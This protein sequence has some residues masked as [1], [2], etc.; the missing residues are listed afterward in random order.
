MKKPFSLEPVAVEYQGKRAESSQEQIVLQLKAIHSQMIKFFKIDFPF[1]GDVKVVE[2]VE[3]QNQLVKRMEHDLKDSN[4]IRNNDKWSQVSIAIS[5][6]YSAGLS[7]HFAFYDPQNDILHFN[8]KMV[9]DYPERVISVCAHEL[10]E[11]LLSFIDPSSQKRSVQHAAKLYFETTNNPD[12]NQLQQV[13]D[14]YFETIFKTIFKEGCCEAIA[15]QILRNMNFNAEAARSDKELQS[16]YLKCVG[17]LSI[18]ECKRK[19]MMAAEP[20]QTEQKPADVQAIFGE[21]LKH[22]QIIKSV[23]YYLGYPLAREVLEKYGLYGVCSLIQKAMQPK[24]EHFVNP[25]SY[26]AILETTFSD[27]MEKRK[28]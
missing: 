17:L 6:D 7:E 27:Q 15:I 16:G 21:V 12:I 4:I 2:R 19:R 10:A 26:I 13:V 8:K 22:A 14:V 1:F 23:S 28:L 5:R 3:F 11:K 25:E 9:T 24:A 18:I 20:L